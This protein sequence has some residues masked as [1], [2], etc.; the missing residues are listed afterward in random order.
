M[1]S[2]RDD[3]GSAAVDQ[4]IGRVLAA[5]AAARASVEAAA[6]EA[7]AEVEAARRDARTIVERT[8]RRVRLACARHGAAVADRVARIEALAE[9][10]SVRHDVTN[11][12]LALAIR[13]A[14]EIAAELTGGT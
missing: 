2:D 1:T 13:A 11:G 5:E 7:A 6:R 12:E 14:V 4:A 3:A 9:A 8:E 10:Q